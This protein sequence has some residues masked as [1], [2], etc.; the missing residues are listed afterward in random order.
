M[1]KKENTA[2]FCSPMSPIPLD[3]VIVES[4]DPTMADVNYQCSQT[5]DYGEVDTKAHQIGSFDIRNNNY[6]QLMDKP[7]LNDFN[8][9]FG[10]SD[11]N[12][13]NTSIKYP[14]NHDLA[15]KIISQNSK[16]NVSQ[17][18]Q[19]REDLQMID[20][21][22]MQKHHALNFLDLQRNRIVSAS[23]MHAGSRLGKTGVSLVFADKQ[24]EC[25]SHSPSQDY[26]SASNSVT[27]NP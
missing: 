17:S 12:Y 25:A 8:S 14:L 27:H 26:R 10:V 22:N 21:A 5:I 13:I 16:R 15:S 19:I 18:V 23:T 4:I 7:N 6:T 11:N 24:Q 3:E 1:N 9:S 2:A 20:N